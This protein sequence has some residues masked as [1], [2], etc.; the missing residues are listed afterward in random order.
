MT[1]RWSNGFTPEALQALEEAS[2]VDAEEGKTQQGWLL[3]DVLALYP[4]HVAE[5]EAQITVSSSSRE[6]SIDLTWA[7]VAEPQKPRA[8]R[9]L[10][11]RDPQIGL[12]SGEVRYPRRVGTGRR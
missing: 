3:R 12:G 7:E 10:R 2:F 11:A 8:V 6:K 4:T 9:S 5:A 1:G